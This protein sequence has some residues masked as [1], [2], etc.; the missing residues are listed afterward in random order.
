MQARVSTAS[1]GLEVLMLRFNSWDSGVHN[2]FVRVLEFLLQNQFLESRLLLGD[3]CEDVIYR[4]LTGTGMGLAHSSDI[5]DLCLFAK[6]ETYLEDLCTRYQVSWLARY[7]DDIL[8]EVRHYE[9][10]MAVV[11]K[12]DRLSDFYDCELEEASQEVR[13][14]DMTILLEHR[15]ERYCI[16]PYQKPWTRPLTDDS[17]HHG[18]IHRSWP[19]ALIKKYFY[20]PPFVTRRATASRALVLAVTGRGLFRRAFGGHLRKANRYL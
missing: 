2:V 6:A 10:G 11:G 16:R 5:A 17:Q 19:K 18:S 15:L 9:L 20:F 8:I 1:A 14:L 7:R 3:L 13:Y 12:Y 4:S